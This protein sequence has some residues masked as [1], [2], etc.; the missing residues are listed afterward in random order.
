MVSQIKSAL[1]LSGVVI[2]SFC[3]LFLASC[4]EDESEDGA[5]PTVSFKNLTDGAE[6]WSTTSVDVEVFDNEGIQKVEVYIDGVIAGTMITEPYSMS[7]NTNTATDGT[8]SVKA[9][10]TDLAGN[11]SE[12]TISV[13]VKNVLV[14]LNIGSGRLWNDEKVFV[15]LSDESGKLI[16]SVEY[17]IGDGEIELKKPDFSGAYF[18]LTE[19]HL[20]TENNVS[21]SYTYSQVERG[22]DWVIAGYPPETV[23]A[24]NATLTFS[25]ALENSKYYLSTNQQW[26]NGVSSTME[27]PLDLELKTEVSKLYVTRWDVNTRVPIEYGIYSGI[28]VGSNNVDFSMVNSELTKST[29]ELPEGILDSHITLY[30]TFIANDFTEKYTIGTF[31]MDPETRSNSFYYPGSA[32]ATYHTFFGYSTDEY[33]YRQTSTTEFYSFNIIANDVSYSYSNNKLIYSA[34]GDF[35]FWHLSFEEPFAFWEFF[36]P[37]GS[38]KVIPLLEIPESLSDIKFPSFGVPYS[39]GVFDIDNIGDYDG[40][41]NSIRQ[42]PLGLRSIFEIESLYTAM[43]YPNKAVGGRLSNTSNRSIFVLQGKLIDF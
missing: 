17:K 5:N 13:M 10:V 11:R 15:F 42:S 2:L 21:Q 3:S 31:F 14:T 26:Y 41:K 9:V 4:T 43:T 38:N 16:T 35:D 30:G 36:L 27:T 32:F 7:W 1:Y 34:D 20:Y 12:A 8:H 39:H 18:F 22:K 37:K 29:I 19:V 25:N 40:L 6:V 33:N 24:G 28:I 23:S